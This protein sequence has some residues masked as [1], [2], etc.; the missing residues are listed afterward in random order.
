MSSVGSEQD[1]DD[2]VS[3][4]DPVLQ[5]YSRVFSRR[6]DV[7]GDYCGHELFLIEGDALLLHCFSDQHIDFDPGFQLL[8]ATWAVE[9]FLRGL[10]VRRC[11]FHIAFVDQHRELCIPQSAS[12]EVREK[13]LLA[14]SA[15]IR[16]LR[17]NLK[18]VHTEIEVNVFTSVTSDAFAEYLATTDLYFVMIHD[19]AEPGISRKRDLLS[20]NLDALEDEDHDDEEE[21][22][23]TKIA[24]RQLIYWF[25][26]QG[27]SS[28]LLNGL[29]WRDT[30]VV[31][32]VLENP[33]RSDSEI[34]STVNQ[35][36]P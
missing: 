12:D 11:N 22:L 3:T 17:T 35:I 33:R 36:Q 13:Y 23:R 5:W 14:R 16:H 1:L 30:K 32:T 20:K 9:N 18:P 26:E 15:I 19:G 25:M 7:I 6:I 29:E 31:T 10:L 34:A 8:H 2:V 21:K 24:F 28:A 27:I 4:S